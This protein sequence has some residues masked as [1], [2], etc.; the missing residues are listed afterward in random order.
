MV[1]KDL[2][3]PSVMRRIAKQGQEM[4]LPRETVYRGVWGKS[5][6]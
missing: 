3:L 2:G 6:K 4:E 1:K 5:L